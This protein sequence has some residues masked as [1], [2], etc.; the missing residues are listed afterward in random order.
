MLIYFIIYYLL[1]F[2]YS[3]ILINHI[4]VFYYIFIVDFITFIQKETIEFIFPIIDDTENDDIFNEV[5]V[6]EIDND[7][8]DD[9]ENDP[10]EIQDVFRSLEYEDLDREKNK[11]FFFEVEFYDYILSIKQSISYNIFN[12]IE[13]IDH[14]QLTMSMYQD[15]NNNDFLKWFNS[16]IDNDDNLIRLE[17]ITWDIINLFF[18][19]KFKNQDLQFRKFN[20]DAEDFIVFNNDRIILDLIYNCCKNLYIQYKLSLSTKILRPNNICLTEDQIKNE[21]HCFLGFAIA[22]KIVKFEKAKQEELLYVFKQL[23]E[24][25][26]NLRLENTSR[27]FKLRNNGALVIVSNK[28]LKYGFLLLDIIRNSMKLEVLLFALYLLLS[29]NFFFLYI[30]NT[31]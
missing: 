31:S 25:D 5:N 22:K 17:E 12:Q 29:N 28:L 8:I 11:Y 24:T 21:V 18:H 2:N 4:F 3:N 6:D 10:H 26:S 27:L 15:D 19:F 20:P 13:F 23:I 1:Y 30:F 9:D 7:E 16:L 14:Y